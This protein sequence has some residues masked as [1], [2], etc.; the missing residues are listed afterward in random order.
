M[1][2]FQ[3]LGYHKNVI[4][5][6][7][8]AKEFCDFVETIP[9]TTLQDTILRLQKFIP[10][11]YLKGSLLPVC[12]CTELGIREDNV[13]EEQYNYLYTELHN[14]LGEHDEYLEVF[15]DNMQYSETPVINS[16][17]EKI[18]DIYQDLKNFIFSYRCGMPEIIE[19]ALWELNNNFELYWGKACVGVLRAIHQV[20]YQIKDEEKKI[21]RKTL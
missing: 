4:E 14:K 16:I 20:V 15:D 2:D 21:D 19:E 18:C 1:E 10:L 12:E 9:S 8:V 7:A 11:I 6:V 13:T 5:F 17:A 3:S